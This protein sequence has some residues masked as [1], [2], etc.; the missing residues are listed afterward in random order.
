MNSSYKEDERKD[1]LLE[2]RLRLHTG[3]LIGGVVH[4]EAHEGHEVNGSAYVRW[5][6]GI[7]STNSPGSRAGLGG[8][9]FHG[10][11]GF[12][13]RSMSFRGPPTRLPDMPTPAEAAR[14]I[15]HDQRRIITGDSS[16]RRCGAVGVQRRR[17]S[18]SG[19]NDMGF[20]CHNSAIYCTR[21]CTAICMVHCL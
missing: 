11:H 19:R 9:G 18:D 8:H 6:C 15:P 10:F 4:H 20:H 7:A 3:L 14:G 13:R 2:R 21:Q 1:I 17:G 16:R 5:R 12:P